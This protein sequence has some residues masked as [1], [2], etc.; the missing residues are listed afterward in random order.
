MCVW[1]PAMMPSTGR[2]EARRSA[3]SYDAAVTLDQSGWWTGRRA[4]RQAGW[5]AGSGTQP[6][7]WHCTSALGEMDGEMVRAMLASA[8]LWFPVVSNIISVRD[9]RLW[10]RFLGQISLKDTEDDFPIFCLAQMESYMK[11]F[12]ATLKQFWLFYCSVGHAGKQ[13]CLCAPR[14]SYTCVF[15]GWCC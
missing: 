4:G 13:W 11:E 14:F 12:L 1:Q 8:V 10:C 5:L 3:L 6:W 9:Y 7:E 2:R 15:A